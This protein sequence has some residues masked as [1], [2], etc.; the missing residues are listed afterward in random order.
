METRTA[1]AAFI[2]GGTGA[3]GSAVTA[4]FLADGMSVA[5]SYRDPAEWRALEGS[6]VKTAGA[7]RLLGFETDLLSEEST[8]KSISA[9]AQ[10]FGGLRVLAHLAG[11]YAGGAT[12][13]SV[14]ARTVRAMIDLNLVSAFWAAKH[15]IPHLK[16]SGAGRLLFVSS[17]GALECY[18]GAAPYAAAKAGLNALVLTLAKELKDAGA[19]A[20]AILPSVIDTAAN[21]AGMPDG[22]FDR[23]VRAE[24]VAALLA[25][26]A[27]EASS[28]TSGALIPIYGRA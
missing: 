20:N 23:W 8:G 2:T 21:R 16:R 3:L 4:R 13:E 11:G 28:A 19:T 25:Y 15:A 17:R 22:K 27:S 10:S 26:L 1:N 6:L 5:V 12:V 18:P 7:G 9:A 24:E 14:E